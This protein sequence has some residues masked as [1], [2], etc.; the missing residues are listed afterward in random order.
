MKPGRLSRG[1]RK[2]EWTH[3]TLQ[4]PPWAQL[5][6][7]AI[8]LVSRAE[9]ASDCRAL[10]PRRDHRQARD[11]RWSRWADRR[12]ATINCGGIEVAFQLNI[13]ISALKAHV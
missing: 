7:K 2:A 4:A 5:R 9:N 6:R 12:I 3:R 8:T 1:E 11:P 13:V 10:A